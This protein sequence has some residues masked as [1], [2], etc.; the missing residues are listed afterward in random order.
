MSTNPKNQPRS[1]QAEDQPTA[2][3]DSAP[4]PE[5]QIIS[6]R[7]AGLGRQIQEL[8]KTEATLHQEYSSAYI[9]WKKVQQERMML[10]RQLAEMY[11]Q[12]LKPA[13]MPRAKSTQAETKTKAK[14]SADIRAAAKMIKGLS[15]DQIKQLL[16]SAGV[17]KE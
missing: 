14:E 15:E 17:E 16:A 9:R 3:D 2:P 8:K 11:K 7:A 1:T 4:S 12:I 5:A 10:E 13:G 6:L